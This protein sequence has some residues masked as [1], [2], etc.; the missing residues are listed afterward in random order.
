MRELC[1]N[2]NVHLIFSGSII[3]CSYQDVPAKITAKI[4]PAIYKYG[5]DGL[6]RIKN[7]VWKMKKAPQP[8]TIQKMLSSSR[9]EILNDSKLCDI[10]LNDSGQCVFNENLEFISDFEETPVAK[11]CSE[12]KRIMNEHQNDTNMDVT[13]YFEWMFKPPYGYIMTDSSMAALGLA[14]RPFINKM[15]ISS[16]SSIV[17]ALRM[18]TFVSELMDYYLRTGKD[19]TSLHIRFS[20]QEEKDLMDVL[21]NTFVLDKKEND[22]LLNIKWNLRDKFKKDNKAPLWVL[23][24]VPKENNRLSSIF[25]DLFEFT[26]KQ[27]DDIDSKIVKN[28][29][30]EI[31]DKRLEIINALSDVKKEDCL[32]LYIN[33]FSKKEKYEEFDLDECIKYL[34]SNL[35]GEIIFWSERDVTD[36]IKRFVDNKSKPANEEP[37]NYPS[38]ER[39]NPVEDKNEYDNNKK[40]FRDKLNSQNITKEKLINTLIKF[41]DKKPAFVKELMELI[42][43]ED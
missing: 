10:L 13:N 24:Y 1:D 17:D 15:F 38:K 30:K 36:F 12:V 2:G 23:K 27:N 8:K 22:G 32:K 26:Q 40:A 43:K 4:L 7:T 42:D 28:L 18:S 33:Y 29:L 31:K 21:I 39:S 34:K 5:L 19:S 14:F 16:T 3:S 35:S 6:K 20:S 9:E 11:L 37:E 25:D 41:V